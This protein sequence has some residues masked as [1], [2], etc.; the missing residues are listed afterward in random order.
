MAMRSRDPG[1]VGEIG[2]DRPRETEGVIK[3]GRETGRRGG[4]ER[5]RHKETKRQRNRESQSPLAGS[6]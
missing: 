1:E 4:K 2:R 5:K 6:D 3:T